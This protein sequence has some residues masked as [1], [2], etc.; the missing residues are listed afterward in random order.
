M[1]VRS[2][3]LL[4]VTGLLAAQTYPPP[5][6]RSG[7]QKLFENARVE[8]WD[9]VWPKGQPS[10]MHQHPFDQISVTLTGGAVRVT[11]LDGTSTVNHSEIGSITPTA[12]GTI[13]IE[14]GLSDIPQHK[15][16]VELKPSAASA[17][18][19]KAGI[20]GA[21]PRE[22]S[23]KVFEDDR[24]IAWDYTWRPGRPAPRHADY[25]DSVAVFLEGGT[26]RAVAGSREIWKATRQRGQAVYSPRSADAYSEELVS[27]T[28]HAVIVELK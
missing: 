20:P 2:L 22:G 25:R 6:P 15:I 3:L 8:L 1:L 17:L 23:I 14:E 24:V 18:P 21:F 28:P 26:L 27:G 11:R 16:M 5:F 7:A 19:T 12:K 4:F 9:V 13:H 10:P